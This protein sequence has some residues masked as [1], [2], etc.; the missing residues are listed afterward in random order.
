MRWHCRLPDKLC[1]SLQT[2]AAECP[3]HSRS[4]QSS[5]RCPS[6]LPRPAAGKVQ[7]KFL[8]LAPPGGDIAA[9]LV[10]AS[11]YCCECCLFLRTERKARPFLSRATVYW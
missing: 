10:E 4:L 8:L 7:R 5:E 6:P 11:K 9:A 3:P 1:S 2:F